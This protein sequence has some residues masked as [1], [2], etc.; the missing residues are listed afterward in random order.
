MANDRPNSEN[1]PN[2]VT[3]FA[4]VIRFCFVATEKRLE[5]LGR[6]IESRH[7]R[8]FKKM[9]HLSLRF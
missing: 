2:L 1:S 6:E 5:L 8:G 9:Y 7:G 4:I 3:L